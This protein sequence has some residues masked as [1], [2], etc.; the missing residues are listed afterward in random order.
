M[1]NI[2]RTAIFFT[3]PQILNKEERMF[4]KRKI[5]FLQKIVCLNYVGVRCLV[6]KSIG[7]YMVVEFANIFHP[8][9]RAE[10]HKWEVGRITVGLALCGFINSFSVCSK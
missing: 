5:A 6:W 3:V 10:R 7:Q 1:C 9:L 2:E 8:T 4:C